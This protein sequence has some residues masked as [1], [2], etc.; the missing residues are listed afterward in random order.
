MYCRYRILVKVILAVMK[1]LKQLK[2]QTF[3]LGFLCNCF[4]CFVTARIT[5]TSNLVKLHVTRYPR[6]CDLN[7]QLFSIRSSGGRALTRQM[8]V[9]DMGGKRREI[10]V[11]GKMKVRNPKKK[12]E[13][14]PQTQHEGK[15]AAKGELFLLKLLTI[16]Y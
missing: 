15:D 12:K 13:E 1:Q 7:L 9:S 3:F 5:F 6:S 10:V 8:S 4:S 14:K 2:P 11:P 16:N